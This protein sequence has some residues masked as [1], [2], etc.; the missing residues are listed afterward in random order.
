MANMAR[1][2]PNYATDLALGGAT[3]IAMVQNAAMAI[4]AGMANTVLCVHARH[5]RS[6]S[7]QPDPA[8]R[9]T[10]GGALGSLLRGGESRL[11]GAA[12]HV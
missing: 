4:E 2:Q 11:R 5:A 10:L 3:P 7:G 12:P 9:R 6:L 1:I 8:R